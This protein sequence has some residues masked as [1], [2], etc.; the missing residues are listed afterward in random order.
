MGDATSTGE[1]LLASTHDQA[2]AAAAAFLCGYTRNTR[3]GYDRDLTLWLTFCRRRGLDPFTVKRPAIELFGREMEE[4]GKAPATVA[5][6]LSTV[7]VWYGYLE[8]E[9]I[10]AK[11]PAKHV[12]RPKVSMESTTLGLDRA[13][14]GALLY[15]AERARSAEYAL[16]ALMGLNGLRVS[17]ACGADIAGLGNQRGHRTLSIVGKGNKPALIPLAPRT[18]RA[19]D[20]AVGERHS[21]RIVLDTRGLPMSRGSAAWVVDKLA[22]RARIAHHVSPHSLRH[23][24]V[25]GCLDAGVPLRDVQEGARHADPRTT[26][27][28]DRARGN[29]DRHPTYVLSAFVSGAA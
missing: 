11:S 28:Y 5:R 23:A 2:R 1:L 21:G 24:F 15:A 9:E 20:Q 25:T 19:V 16:I 12:R 17:E 6:R 27:R 8:A 7:C 4:A 3:A 10:I 13:Q 18:A 14:L 22:R 26:I 29:L